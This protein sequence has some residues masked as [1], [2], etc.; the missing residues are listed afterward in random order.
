[1]CLSAL[2]PP[3]YQYDGTD[4]SNLAVDFAVVWNGN[5]IIDNPQDLKG[6]RL[7]LCPPACWSTRD[8]GADWSRRD[9][10][11]PAAAP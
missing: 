9:P 6:E 2:P 10:N 4:I 5:F 11:P 3:Q 8:P 1:M 7:P